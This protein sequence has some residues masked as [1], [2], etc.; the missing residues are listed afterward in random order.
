MSAFLMEYSMVHF[1]R[2]AIFTLVAGTL[3]LAPWP[4]AAGP[5]LRRGPKINDEILSLV[6]VTQAGLRIDVRQPQGAEKVKLPVSLLKKQL[7]RICAEKGLQVS[8]EIE[9]V[10]ISIAVEFH[11]NPD[12]AE[13]MSY[14]AHLALEQKMLLAHLKRS[15]VVPTYT[16][17]DG[18]F[19]KLEDLEEKVPRNLFAMMYRFLEHHERAN[20][21]EK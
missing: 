19:Y 18:G 7:Q 4:G 13:L 6:G 10:R 8:S 21:A 1:K 3:L 9:D 5:V 15:M 2:S 11:P 16:L 17:I 20:V 12:Y 14:T